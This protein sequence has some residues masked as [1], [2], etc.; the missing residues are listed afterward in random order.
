MVESQPTGAL[1]DGATGW[2]MVRSVMSSFPVSSSFRQSSS[3]EVE[4]SYG[5]IRSLSSG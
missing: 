5:S 3:V 4:V 2:E 1:D